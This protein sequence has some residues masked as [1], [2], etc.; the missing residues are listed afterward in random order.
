MLGIAGGSVDLVVTA[1]ADHA[2][3]ILDRPRIAA[4]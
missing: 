4:L 3:E 2:E 1:I